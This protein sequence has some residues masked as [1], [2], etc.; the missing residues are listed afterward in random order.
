MGL[1]QPL[2]FAAVTILLLTVALTASRV[3][4]R[5]AARVEPLVCARPQKAA[6]ATASPAPLS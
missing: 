2:T 1:G 3:P 6:T 5:R 4:A